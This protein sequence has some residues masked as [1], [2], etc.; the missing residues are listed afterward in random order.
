LVNDRL[1]RILP[2]LWAGKKGLAM[3]LIKEIKDRN[4]KLY[5]KRW[6]LLTTPWFYLEVHEFWQ[7]K[8]DPIFD[9]DGHL[10]NHPNEF[11]S[12]ILK[13]GYTEVKKK[14]RF[15]PEET[16]VRKLFNFAFVDY[17]CFHRVDTLLGDYCK[18]FIIKKAARNEYWGYLVNGELICH[19]DYRQNKNPEDKS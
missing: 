6:R 5:F 14:D 4:G 3:K 10:H 17:K 8:E 11:W 7:D 15:S 1:L 19:F 12:L 2:G 9:K 13:G 16:N 18:T